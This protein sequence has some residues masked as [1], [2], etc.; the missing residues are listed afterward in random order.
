MD[1]Q[2]FDF[3]QLSP[4]TKT[5]KQCQEYLK[6]YFVPLM[7]GNHAVL[8]DGNYEI[9]DQPTV[10]KVYFNRMPKYK[11]G[12]DGDDDDGNSKAF[13]F[14]NWYFK[15]YTDLR[16]ITYELNKEV[17]FDDK[18]N[19]CPRMKH[20]YQPYDSFPKATRAKVKVML[21]Y[22]NEVLASGNKSVFTY[23]LQ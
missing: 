19:L 14:S 22:M 12:S 16:S 18:L 6:K 17:L 7:D 15:K 20:A 4:K 21:N 8:K 3:K 2:N 9:L 10:T 11:A 23:L 5:L 13:D 1:I